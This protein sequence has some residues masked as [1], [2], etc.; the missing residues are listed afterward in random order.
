MEFRNFS[1]CS[2]LRSGALATG[3]ALLGSS[4]AMAQSSGPIKPPPTTPSAPQPVMAP[5]PPVPANETPKPLEHSSGAVRAEQP[6]IPVD[7]IIQRFAARELEFK[8]ERDNFTYS[9]TFHI[10]ELDPDGRPSGEYRMDSDI[11]FTPEGRR[12]EKVTFA[13]PPSLQQIQLSPQDLQDLEYIQPFV[14]T[15][16]QLGKYDIK[17]VGKED[18]DAIDTYVFDVSP[19][20]MDK[21]QRYLLGRI[22][23][24]DKDLEIVKSH[25]KSTGLEDTKKGAENVSPIFDTYRQNI[26]GSYWFPVLSRADDVLHFRES[27]LDVHIRMT[28]KYSN[29]KRYG[30][31]IKIKKAPD[32]P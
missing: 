2:L 5:Q 26:E 16:D 19:K 21:G 7:Q 3:L 11:I 17:Y 32:Q 10:E 25:G 18:V 31:T 30:S 29:Y 6:K 8:K 22:W 1:A 15:T 9:Q 12:Y 27:P 4:A 23:V 24:D 28:V 20:K 14:L 13:P